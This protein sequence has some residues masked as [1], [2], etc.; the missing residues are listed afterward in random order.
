MKWTLERE[1]KEKKQTR[2]TW[3]RDC[4][5]S[6]LGFDWVGGFLK[7]MLW[8]KIAEIVSFK[9]KNTNEVKVEREM[10]QILNLSRFESFRKHWRLRFRRNIQII[11]FMI[12]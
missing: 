11:F 7:V 3:I 8:F 2:K 4:E 12:L 6:L 5:L 9:S 1:R 10:I